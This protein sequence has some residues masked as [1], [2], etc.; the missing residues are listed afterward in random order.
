MNELVKCAQELKELGVG[1]FRLTLEGVG[2]LEVN[3]APVRPASESA[4]ISPLTGFEDPEDEADL[5]FAAG[6]DLTPKHTSQVL[7]PDEED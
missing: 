5:L 2:S 4:K 3:F 6:A 1:A 7:L